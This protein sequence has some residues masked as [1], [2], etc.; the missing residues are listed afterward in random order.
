MIDWD[1]FWIIFPIIGFSVA[2]GW[3]FFGILGVI[4]ALLLCLV[5]DRFLTIVQKD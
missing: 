3:Y 1:L 5:A 4:V 2:V